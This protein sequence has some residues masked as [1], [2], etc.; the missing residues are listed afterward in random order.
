DAANPG[1][2][3]R[4]AQRGIDL[5]LV[6]ALYVR[7]EERRLDL[8]LVARAMDNRVLAA[9]ANYAS[10]TGRH[11]SFGLSGVWGPSG[12]VLERTAAPDETLVVVDL[13][14]SQLARYRG[15]LPACSI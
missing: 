12:E 2:A 8:H 9:L 14:P 13:D 1:H 4:A 10:T 3:E 6:S 7:G 15:M 5:Y 11:V